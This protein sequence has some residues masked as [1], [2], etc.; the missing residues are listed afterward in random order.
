[1][2]VSGN[3]LADQDFKDAVRLGPA[4]VKAVLMVEHEKRTPHHLRKWYKE[5]LHS[6]H[7]STSS[8]PSRDVF[9]QGETPG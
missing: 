3:F 9:S 6:H 1:M 2:I 7:Q 4:A 8:P 5:V